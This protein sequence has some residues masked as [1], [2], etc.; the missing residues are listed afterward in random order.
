MFVCYIEV[1]YKKAKYQ[2]IPQKEMQNFR[3]FVKTL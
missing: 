3:Y 2:K 1:F